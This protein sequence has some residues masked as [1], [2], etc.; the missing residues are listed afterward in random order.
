MEVPR[1]GVESELQMSAYTTATAMPDRTCICDLYHSSWQCQILNP[2]G[3]ARDQAHILLD[4]IWV[5]YCWA[6][7]RTP[8]FIFFLGLHLE[9]MEAPGLGWNQSCSCQPTL[10]PQQRRIQAASATYATA[11]GNAGSLTHW[12]RPGIEAASSQTL[13]QT[14][15]FTK[16]HRN[17]LFNVLLW[18]FT[19][20]NKSRREHVMNLLVSFIHLQ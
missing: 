13:C 4:T 5:H 17:S 16:P 10:Q 11:Y 15:T 7:M 3:E 19:N 20:L 2:L 14:L 12:V 8:I 6:T 1:L 18:K 9:Q